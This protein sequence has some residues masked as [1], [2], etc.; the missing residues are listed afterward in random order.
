MH[1][2]WME[3]E[4]S[5][6][7]CVSKIEKNLMEQ[8]VFESGGKKNVQSSL[9]STYYVSISCKSMNARWIICKKLKKSLWNK[10][11]TNEINFLKKFVFGKFRV[12]HVDWCASQEKNCSCQQWTAKCT[13]NEESLT[14]FAA[15]NVHWRISIFKHL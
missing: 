6:S 12:E 5:S 8:I 10:K 9:M 4:F 13:D 11:M 14:I 7:Y 15:C 1:Q 3:M 2:N